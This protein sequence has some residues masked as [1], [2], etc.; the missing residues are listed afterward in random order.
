MMMSCA[1]TYTFGID[2]HAKGALACGATRAEL[3]DAV[4]ATIITGGIVA[5]VEG[6]GPVD[7][8]LKEAGK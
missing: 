1:E 6:F 3:V 2:V 8:A 7:N 5:W 4:R